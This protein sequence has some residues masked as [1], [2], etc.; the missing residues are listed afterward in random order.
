[1]SRRSL[2]AF[3]G[4]VLAAVLLCAGAAWFSTG[5]GLL[6]AGVCVAALTVVAFVDVGG[7]A[8]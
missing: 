3:V 2:A 5:A 7:D 4:F 8:E 6:T 1:M